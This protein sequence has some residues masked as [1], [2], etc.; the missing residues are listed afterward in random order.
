MPWAFNIKSTLNYLFCQNNNIQCRHRL[1]KNQSIQDAY[2]VYAKS[3]D[4]SSNM[5]VLQKIHF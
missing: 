1:V 3:K 5:I 4:Q 2:K